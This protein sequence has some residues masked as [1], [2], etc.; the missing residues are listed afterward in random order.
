MKH[1]LVTGAGSGI[2]AVIALSL[3]EAGYRVSLLGRRLEPLATT[4]ASAPEGSCQTL[5]CDVGKEEDV[6]TSSGDSPFSRRA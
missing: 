5:T 1:A 3:A 6:A 4:A 2:G